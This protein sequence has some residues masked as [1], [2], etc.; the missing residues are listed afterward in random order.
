MR[1]GVMWGPD[2]T[3]MGVRQL[4]A[5]TL[6]WLPPTSMTR[7]IIVVNIVDPAGFIQI[8]LRLRAR[9]NARHSAQQFTINEITFAFRKCLAG[10][11][12]ELQVFVWQAV[13]VA[14]R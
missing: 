1:A 8:R 4:L 13:C 7:T 14:L 2:D 9:Q 6:T 11:L 12:A 3:L 5:R 10:F